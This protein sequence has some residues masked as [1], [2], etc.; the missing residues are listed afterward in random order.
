MGMEGGSGP[1]CQ[2]RGEWPSL[3]SSRVAPSRVAVL[4]KVAGASS[5]RRSHGVLPKAKGSDGSDGCCTGTKGMWRCARHWDGEGGRWHGGVGWLVKVWFFATCTC[6]T[7][8]VSSV[9]LA[10]SASCAWARSFSAHN[11]ATGHIISSTFPHAISQSFPTPSHGQA[12]VDRSERWRSTVGAAVI[13]VLRSSN[14]FADV[15]RPI[16]PAQT[17]TALT[18]PTRNQRTAFFLRSGTFVDLSGQTGGGWGC[19]P[20]CKIVVSCFAAPTAQLAAGTGILRF[21]L[22]RA[23]AS[24]LVSVRAPLL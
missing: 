2:G 23:A 10:F 7:S 6:S 1:R 20:V 9:A 18:L 22:S 8:F 13:S 21:C 16:F 17:V 4:V 5:R 15:Y 19:R 11:T 12:E 24:A 14:D 3:I